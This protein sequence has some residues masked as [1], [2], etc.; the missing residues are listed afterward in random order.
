M[1]LYQLS[2]KQP[3]CTLTACIVHVFNEM[4]LCLQVFVDRAPLMK[5]S[6]YSIVVSSTVVFGA[7]VAFMYL[8]YHFRLAPDHMHKWE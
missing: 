1:S 4:M 3:Y 7:I 2:P 6:E 8:L 5:A